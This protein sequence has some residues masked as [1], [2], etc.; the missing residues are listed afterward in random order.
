[1]GD[2]WRRDHYRVSCR[3]HVGDR[4]REEFASGDCRI[5]CWLRLCVFLR[6]TQNDPRNHTKSH[7]QSGFV[8]RL[9]WPTKLFKY[10]TTS[11]RGDYCS[12]PVNDREIAACISGNARASTH[13]VDLMTEASGA[14]SRA[15]GLR[16]CACSWQRS[17]SRN[18]RGRR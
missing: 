13:S 10:F 9:P 3:A 11:I 16:S 1:M 8:D 15:D 12:K 2:Y 14:E 7:E 4:E 6:I 5:V 17:A 18:C